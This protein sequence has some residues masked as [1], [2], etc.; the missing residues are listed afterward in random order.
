MATNKKAAKP[1]KENEKKDKPVK[2][3]KPSGEHTIKIG[4]KIFDYRLK[5]FR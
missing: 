3:A 2:P 4:K 1:A 5:M